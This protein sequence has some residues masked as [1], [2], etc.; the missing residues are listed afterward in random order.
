[1]LDL[2][3]AELTLQIYS[4]L[5]PHWQSNLALSCKSLWLQISPLIKGHKALAKK[6]ASILEGTSISFRY[7]TYSRINHICYR[8]SKISDAA[9]RDKSIQTSSLAL[10]V[11]YPKMKTEVS[12]LSEIFSIPRMSLDS[13]AMV[14]LS[15]F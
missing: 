6:C 4:C 15:K 3:P 7:L 12:D 14:S 11:L 2:L 5:L 10:S 9:R 1:M 13:F 8:I